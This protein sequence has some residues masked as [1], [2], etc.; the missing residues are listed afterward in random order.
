MS[1]Q[2]EVERFIPT[3]IEQL[4]KAKSESE[5][6]KICEEMKVTVD[7]VFGKTEGRRDPKTMAA[8]RK[9]IK[10]H[11]PT[12]SVDGD[13]ADDFPYYFT[14]KGQGQIK[15]L[16]HLA[17]KHLGDERNKKTEQPSN[18]PEQE[19]NKTPKPEQKTVKVKLKVNEVS[20]ESF[21]LSNNEIEAVKQAVGDTDIKEWVKQAIMQR[22]KAVNKLRES[23]DADWSS[24][25][26]EVL[27]KDKRY[28]TNSAACRELVSR[29]VR[30]IK[31]WNHD[32]PDQKWCITNKLISELTSITVKAI[33]KAVEGMDNESYNQIQDLSPV[34]N[35]IV[36]ATVGEPSKVMSLA[37]VTG[38][39]GSEVNYHLENVT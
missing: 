11:F 13:V 21:G 31:A 26:S 19:Q 24:M 8:I 37:N 7:R 10:T 28:R 15:R 30:V 39:E 38:V 33:A 27:I 6:S 12:Q 35:R 16:E 14:N 4:E 1:K 36:R 32:H 29:A 18:E 5:I 25:P 17:Y 22:A 9:A 2:S 20:L 3:F 34:V 23:L